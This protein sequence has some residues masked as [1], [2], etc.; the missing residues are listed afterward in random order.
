MTQIPL[1]PPPQFDAEAFTS[2]PSEARQSLCDRLA[3]HLKARA[4]QW[5]DG[6]ELATVAGAYGWR[7][8]V[9]ELRRAPY[10]LTIENRLRR[11]GRYTISEY[12]LCLPESP[13]GEAA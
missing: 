11:E 8:R 9:S 4:G 13:R 5:I 6:R 10:N 7:T 2:S 1:L 3:A 12:R